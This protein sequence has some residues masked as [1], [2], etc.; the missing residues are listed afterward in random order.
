MALLKPVCIVY[1]AILGFVVIYMQDSMGCK[2]P[3]TPKT[4][5][6]FLIKETLFS[7]L[8]QK[9]KVQSSII[10]CSVLVAIARFHSQLVKQRPKKLQSFSFALY[11]LLLGLVDRYSSHLSEEDAVTI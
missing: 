8:I 5:V 11:C 6:R 10:T 4:I 9:T 7:K 1:C 3:I 2:H